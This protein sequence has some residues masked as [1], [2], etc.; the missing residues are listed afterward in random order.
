MRRS[1]EFAYLSASY[2]IYHLFMFLAD[3]NRKVLVTGSVSTENIPERSHDATKK[4]GR[5]VLVT[6]ATTKPTSSKPSTSSTSVGGPSAPVTSYT[7]EGLVRHLD[8]KKTK[9]GL[10]WTVDKSIANEIRLELYDGAHS[11]PRYTV[12]VNSGMNFS[13]FVYQW[14]I[15][16]DHAIYKTRN[17][18]LRRHDIEELLEVLETSCLCEG[19]PHNDNIQVVNVDP[20]DNVKIPGSVIRHS[21]PKVI[22]DERPVLRLSCH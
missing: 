15:P 11:L 13:I 8:H 17:R 14:P 20:T 9:H 12:I 21:V 4:P 1:S 3:N 2:I 19:L 10:K 5:R 7:F 16:D 6:K 18:S 22:E